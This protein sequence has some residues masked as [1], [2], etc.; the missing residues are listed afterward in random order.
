MKEVLNEDMDLEFTTEFG[1]LFQS[2]T[3]LGKKEYLKLFTE[4]EKTLSFKSFLRLV[5]EVENE[6]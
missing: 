3:V 1:R 6:R 5:T 2:M 4:G